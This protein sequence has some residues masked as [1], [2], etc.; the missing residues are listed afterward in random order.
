MLS[1]Q[2]ILTQ[3]VGDLSFFLGQ[4]FSVLRRMGGGKQGKDGSFGLKSSLG[5]LQSRG[6]DKVNVTMYTYTCACS[7]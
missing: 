5:R 7:L 4:K 1:L 6:T 3:T 2:D